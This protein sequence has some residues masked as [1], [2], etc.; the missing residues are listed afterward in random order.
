MRKSSADQLS[1]FNGEAL[2]YLQ[3]ELSRL[4]YLG[5]SSVLVERYEHAMLR[6]HDHIVKSAGRGQNDSADWGQVKKV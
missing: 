6:Y 3:E 4:F 1:S 2:F 5:T